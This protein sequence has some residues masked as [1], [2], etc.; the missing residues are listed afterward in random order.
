MHPKGKSKWMYHTFPAWHPQ[1]N[2]VIDI[3]CSLYVT[4]HIFLKIFLVNT[5]ICKIT[6]SDV[7]SSCAQ[8]TTVTD[9]V[10][11]HSIR[12]SMKNCGKKICHIRRDVFKLLTSF[13]DL[14]LFYIQLRISHSLQSQA[15]TQ[16]QLLVHAACIC[17]SV[18]LKLTFSVNTHQSLTSITRS[19]SL[20]HHASLVHFPA[21]AQAPWSLQSAKTT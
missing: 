15:G 9:S 4:V 16:N 6:W 8:Q 2:E 14:H 17:R 3:K 1:S 12:S 11:A 5:R 20:V 7:F 10:A 21:H 13:G 19:L 18:W